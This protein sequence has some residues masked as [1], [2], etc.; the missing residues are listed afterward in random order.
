MLQKTMQDD[1]TTWEVISYFR[2]LAVEVPRFGYR[3]KDDTKGCP[4]AICW[5]LPHMLSNLLHYG[6]VL[7]LDSMKEKGFNNLAWP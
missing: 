7:F 3:V 1:G 6:N 5:M 2:T 4:K